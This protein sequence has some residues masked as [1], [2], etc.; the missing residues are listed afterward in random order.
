[1]SVAV[2]TDPAPEREETR[3]IKAMLRIFRAECVTQLAKRLRHD[4]PK[5]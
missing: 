4:V 3:N 1:M 2:P 5:R